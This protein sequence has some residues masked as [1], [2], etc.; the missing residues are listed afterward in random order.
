M[1]GWSQKNLDMGYRV[2]VYVPFG[3]DWYKYSVRRLKENPDIA[4][5]IIKN[6][7]SR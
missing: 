7:F 4:G 5:Y 6:I 1:H 3:G 2:R